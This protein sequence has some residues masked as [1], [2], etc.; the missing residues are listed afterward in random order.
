MVFR[1]L[2]CSDF[3]NFYG[4]QIYY[5]LGVQFNEDKTWNIHILVQ[6][7]VKI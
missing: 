6:H 3:S 1:Y 5:N 7:T 2:E 4:N